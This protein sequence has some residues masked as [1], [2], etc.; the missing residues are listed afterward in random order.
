MKFKCFLLSILCLL[1]TVVSAHWHQI[2]RAD[3]N[4]GPFY[5]YTISLFSETGKYEYEQRPL[6][7]TF[8]YGKPI[9]GKSFGINVI[10]DLEKL[11]IEDFSIDN[12]RVKLKSLF[13]D[14][15]PNDSLSY[16]ALEDRGYFIFNDR[17][18]DGE[19]D[20]I[21]SQAFISIWLSQNTD[22]PELQKK[23]LGI[24][25]T[26]DKSRKPE[27]ELDTPIEKQYKPQLPP[28]YDAPNSRDQMS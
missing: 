16:I 10:K 8:N 9:E 17:V 21:F 25:K 22:Y 11:A 2:G 15:S 24:E 26:D 1:S 20:N 6:M 7:L 3:Y 14:I 23:L 28:T 4:W 27:P 18:L 13:P 5:I 12:Y 19:F